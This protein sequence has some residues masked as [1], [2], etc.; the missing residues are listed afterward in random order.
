MTETT[1]ATSMPHMDLI[2]GIG[3]TP[4]KE[5]MLRELEECCAW[6]ASDDNLIYPNQI[7]TAYLVNHRADILLIM[8]EHPFPFSFLHFRMHTL[9]LKTPIAI[10]CKPT[11]VSDDS[12]IIPLGEQ[13]VRVARGEIVKRIFPDRRTSDRGDAQ[14]RKRGR[15]TNAEA[16]LM[17]AKVKLE[18][19]RT[20]TYTVKFAGGD[21]DMLHGMCAVSGL[22]A[23]EVVRRATALY[24][25]ILAKGPQSITHG[26]MLDIY[27]RVQGRLTAVHNVHHARMDALNIEAQLLGH[28]SWSALAEHVVEYEASLQA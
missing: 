14:R 16:E 26:Q 18:P 2:T 6:E 22:G 17:P 21:A 4:P 10:N 7:L 12:L 19:R 5:L 15:P 8:N 23:S 24:D 1:T 13:P 11:A 9:H 25:A 28:K 3:A 27:R 20:S